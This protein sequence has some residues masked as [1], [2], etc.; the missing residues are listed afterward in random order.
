MVFISG[1]QGVPPQ[2][3]QG[4]DFTDVTSNDSCVSNVPFRLKYQEG[5]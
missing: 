3:R 2:K 5:G 1:S 4:K